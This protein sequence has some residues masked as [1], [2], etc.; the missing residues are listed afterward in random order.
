MK[1]K[2]WYSLFLI[3]LSGL[4]VLASLAG[5]QSSP[6]EKPVVKVV[7]APYFGTWLCNYAIL[8]GTLTSD[9]VDVQID[10]S[11]KFDDE[12]MAGN[13]V[14]GA[15]GVTAFAIST[16]RGNAPLESLGVYLAHTGLDS[17]KGMVVVYTRKG[18]DITSPSQLVGKKVGV[19][20][21]NS[22]T[23]ATFLG[24][25]KNEYNVSVDQLNIVDSTGPLLLDFLRKG[26]V[27]AIV[28]IGDF[29]VRAYYDPDF[30]ILWNVDTDFENTYQTYDTASMLAVQ[31]SYLDGNPETVRAVY[32]LLVA[33]R[34]YGVEH[35]VELSEKYVADFGGSAEFY[36]NAYRNHYSVTLAPVE[37]PVLTAVMAIIGFVK[38][39]GVIDQLPNPDD[40]FVTW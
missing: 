37:G 26:D 12:M 15:M 16:E 22:G 13:Y 7:M 30:Q 17:T 5:C 21:I 28:V 3:L 24:M 34:N 38:D 33:S 19:Q 40:V 31:K 1:N 2:K 10:Q 11:I 25:L 35:I 39:R 29:T 14:M 20:G 36:Q 23:T 8:S 4:L 6:T 27:D 9:K 18:S 32:D